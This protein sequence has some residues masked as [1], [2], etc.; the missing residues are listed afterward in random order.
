[1]NYIGSKQSLL[2]FLT[3]SINKIVGTDLSDMVF[4]DIFAGTGAVGRAYKTK[5]KKVIAN[6]WEYYSYVLNRNYIGNHTAMEDRAEFIKALNTLTLKNDGFIF[7]NY[8]YGSGCG[9]QYFSDENG[10]KI[11]SIRIKIE[12]WKQDYTISDDMY[13]YLLA[14]LIE[15]A[16]KVANTASVYGAFLKRLKASAAKAMVLQGAEYS[17]NSNFHEVYCQ[18][19]NK[20]I[21]TIEGDILYIDPPYNARQYGA[22]YHLLNTIAEYKTF[23]PV[24]KTGLR[25]YK[26]SSYCRKDS[27]KDSF[28]TLIKDARFK[29]IVLSYNNEGLMPP[30]FIKATMSK[31]GHYD[32]LTKEYSRFKADNDKNRRHTANSTIE[33]LHFLNK[34]Y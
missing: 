15:S 16:D 18:D 29:F 27:V 10:K 2:P 20:L 34:N 28:E 4:C 31:Y 3:D 9:R 22:N 32:V 24:G 5:V 23:S 14:S 33:Y 7:S 11:D 30:E 25:E 12:E 26:R 13:F 1:M 6:D 21:K 8:C 17:V 19:A